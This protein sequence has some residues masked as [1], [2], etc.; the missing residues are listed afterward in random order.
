MKIKALMFFMVLL[1]GCQ[2][3]D[4]LNQTSEPE[5]FNV[6]DSIYINETQYLL[7]MSKIEA[8]SK[9]LFYETDCRYDAS[10]GVL[11]YL[12]YEE[13]LEIYDKE[14]WRKYLQD[15]DWFT[16][17]AVLWTQNVNVGLFG[18]E[19]VEEV[20]QIVTFK[21]EDVDAINYCAGKSLP[22]LTS[23]GLHGYSYFLQCHDEK[24]K[25]LDELKMMIES[26]KT[27]LPL[28]GFDLYT[29]TTKKYE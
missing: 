29:T 24:E 26:A 6:L 8:N 9:T 2:S 23:Q 12:S 14:E 11:F 22:I 27:D 16:N 13:G 19:G 15:L 3:V 21:I 18:K 20:G 28:L 1:S 5:E 4:K 17:N 25:S 10:K 7:K